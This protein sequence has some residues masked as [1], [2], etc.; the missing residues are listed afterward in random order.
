MA[1][2]RVTSAN[3]VPLMKE[4]TTSVAAAADSLKELKGKVNARQLGPPNSEITA[5][6][7]DIII[8]SYMIPILIF[9][10]A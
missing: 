9:R 7:A 2:N 4:L 6:L 3:I 5:L 8:V 10:N 1:G